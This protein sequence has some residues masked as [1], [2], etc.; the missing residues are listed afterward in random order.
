MLK[1]IWCWKNLSYVKECRVERYS[2]RE[3][4]GNG[5]ACFGT[6]V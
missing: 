2:C 5:G 4:V 3:W 6:E 1:L